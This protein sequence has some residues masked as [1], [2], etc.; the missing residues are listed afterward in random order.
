MTLPDKTGI[1]GRLPLNH[2][3]SV[4][5]EARDVFSYEVAFKIEVIEKSG[6]VTSPH[7]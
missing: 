4:Q 7:P 2:T 1:P 5:Q 3:R 6:E